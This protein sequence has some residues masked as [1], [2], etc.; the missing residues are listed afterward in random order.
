MASTTVGTKGGTR[1]ATPSPK[2]AEPVPFFR[3]QAEIAGGA[4]L[5][6]LA[7]YLSVALAT[8]TVT[9]PSF[10]QS[11][12]NPVANF[13]GP[14]GAVVS[15][16]LMQVFGLGAV[17]VAVLPTIWGVILAFGKPIDRIWRR[18]WFALAG[19]VLASAAVGCLE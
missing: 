3:R 9:D 17:L 5:L 19:V 13:A 2:R 10:S 14:G 8:W 12:H 15:D 1:Q 4:A 11:N 7:A 6:C 18:A 16:I